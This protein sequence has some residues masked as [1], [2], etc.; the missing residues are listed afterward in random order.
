[1]FPSFAPLLLIILVMVVVLVLELASS[2][3]VA[4]CVLLLLFYLDYLRPAEAFEGFAS[5]VVITI[6]GIFF[7]ST[8]LRETGV[9]DA[10][11]RRIARWAGGDQTR[12][13]VV[14]M[15]A[16]ALLSA[17]MNNV[18]AVAML[19][20]AV[21][22][23]AAHTETPPS[24]LFM[25]L[26]FGVILGGVT[27]LVGTPPNLVAS[28]ILAHHGFE[29]LSLFDITPIGVAIVIAGVAYM[30]LLG[31]RWLPGG[32]TEKRRRD[33]SVLTHAYR[34]EERL[35]SIKVPVGSKLDGAT[36]R[37][38]RMGTALD[39]AVVA[40][41]RGRKKILAPG[42]DFRL[43][44]DDTLLVDGLFADLEHLLNVQGLAVFEVE[45]SRLAA[46]PMAQGLVLSLPAGSGLVGKSLRELR[47]RDRF[48]VLVVGLR[49]GRDLVR[50]ELGRRILRPTDHILA[51]G[52]A[53]Q[54]ASLRDQKGLKVEAEGL[55]LGELMEERFFTLQVPPGSPL[56][57][58]SV[59]ESRLG[60]LAGLTVLGILRGGLLSLAVSGD[61]TVEK[62]DELLVAGEPTRILDL[63]ALGQLELAAEPAG[64][65]LESDTVG[66]AEVVVAPR[67]AAAGSSLR[68]LSFRDRFGL[69]A[70]ALWRG[71][72][73]IAK[74]L[75][76][77]PLRY[78]DALLLHGPI[79]KIRRLAED[80]DFVVL[81]EPEQ[82]RPRSDKAPFAVAALALLI[83]LIVTGAAPT[84]IAA[85]TG[86]M[87]CVVSGAITMPQAYRAIEW[88]ALYF[89]AAIW[90]IGTAMQK[91]GASAF[92]AAGIVGLG[93]HLGPT[94][95]LA[96][97]VC[98]SS[99][100]AQVL[101]GVPA[102]VILGSVAIE[103]ADRLGVSPYPLVVGIGLAASAAFMTPWSH[104]ASL[105]VVNAGGYHTRDFLKVGTPLTVLMLAL[106]VLLV[107]IA[108]PF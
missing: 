90:P 32:Q 84:H 48:G 77:I 95:Y 70:L 25:P 29:P 79:E 20:P 82:E 35:T 39:V 63:V 102:V 55:A 16:S 88:R 62:G 8:A 100:L 27:T 14:L 18:A 56:I 1:M 101:D 57:G 97:L 67:S 3:V 103:V 44:G 15:L 58:R 46:S 28:Q 78:G 11:G 43:E 26:T 92:L 66:V 94:V 5:P 104:K 52:T 89:L 76:N 68:Q 53:E 7:I 13:L 73:T 21:A 10:F 99:L 108:F 83:L 23:I 41:L 72:A 107:P 38:T 42:P 59:R 106:L 61:E 105:L 34:I 4:F 51:L 17:W 2:E 36:L 49:R 6:F 93:E 60:E 30:V 22:S 96:I 86:A 12:L 37:E 47:F 81:L 87:L 65:Q 31:R 74:E 40:V 75:A 80:P 69:Q 19:M 50:E 85:L 24:K 33:A 71:G 45:A 54:V 91:S 98:A 64:T 9:A